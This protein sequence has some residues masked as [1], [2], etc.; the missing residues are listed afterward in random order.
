LGVK[1]VRF[2][3]YVFFLGAMQFHAHVPGP[4]FYAQRQRF[5]MLSQI[6][7]NFSGHAL[8]D[9]QLGSKMS[10]HPGNGTE[11]GNPAIFG[12]V[13]NVDMSKKRHQVVLAKRNKRDVFKG[14]LAAGTRF[15]NGRYSRGS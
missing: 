10:A 3:A 1:K 6:L 14:N 2:N 7:T 11:S 12:C 15:I 8:L 5:E 9:L 4:A 13:V